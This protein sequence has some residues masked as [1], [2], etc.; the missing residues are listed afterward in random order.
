[1]PRCTRW[2]TAAPSR[3]P[4]KRRCWKRCS[5]CGGD[6]LVAGLHPQGCT[7]RQVVV[8]SHRLEVM[9][10]LEAG[11]I[12][13]FLM[14]LGKPRDRADSTRL[15]DQMG[16]K[17]EIFELGPTAELRISTDHHGKVTSAWLALYRAR[18]NAD[19]IPVP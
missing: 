4:P 10:S 1:M 19:F 18:G 15:E 11:G 3:D 8:C 12:H 7:H 9:C 6:S 17:P 2:S 14:A 5:F 13:M 16:G